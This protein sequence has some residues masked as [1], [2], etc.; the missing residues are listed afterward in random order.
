MKVVILAGGMGTRLGEETILRPKPLVEIGG[1]PILWYIMKIYS[2]YGFNDFIICCGYKGP[3]IKEYFIHYH[4]HC[5][6][7]TYDLTD[8]NIIMKK[9]EVE[10]WKVTLVNTG[11]NT[12]TGGRILK[13][14]EYLGNEPFMLTYGDG[15]SDVDLNAL[16]SFHK[17]NGKI[18]TISTT[19][20]QGRFGVVKMDEKSGQ[21][22]RFK[23]KARKDQGWVNMGFMVCNPEIFDYLGD[24]SEMLER[25]PFERLSSEG[26]MMAYRH[27]GFWSPMDTIHDKAYL[28]ELWASG[29][30]PWK[31][32]K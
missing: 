7:C 14:R 26:Q 1:K 11:L 16:I 5:V 18:V 20:P 32:W 19:R 13:V 25:G 21:I 6:D 12:L 29:I 30:A 3:M 8:N 2:A 17:L 24:G 9:T 15:V 28:E 23:E 27:E 31:L 10:P 22:E 4:S